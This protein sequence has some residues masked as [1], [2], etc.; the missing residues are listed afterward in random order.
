MM[1][2]QTLADLA[3]QDRAL[4]SGNDDALEFHHRG[5]C[6]KLP[7]ELMFVAQDGSALLL[8]C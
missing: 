6:C 5:L 4:H 2:R 3:G 1:R 7:D 8:E